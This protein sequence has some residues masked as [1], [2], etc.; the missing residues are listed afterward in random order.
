MNSIEIA[1]TKEGYFVVN[2]GYDS[3]KNKVEILAPQAIDD[4]LNENIKSA[5]IIVSIL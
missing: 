2:I 4:S 1:F 5:L 3:R